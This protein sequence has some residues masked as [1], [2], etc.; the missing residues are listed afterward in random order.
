MTSREG[1]IFTIPLEDGREALCRVLYASSYFKDVVLLGCY[2]C[3]LPTAEQVDA[4]PKVMMYT[5]WSKAWSVIGHKPV[6]SHERTFSRR[7]VAGDV[8]EG[9]KHMGQAT[10]AELTS[11]PKMEVFGHRILARKLAQYV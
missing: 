1:D 4:N 6:D 2:G 9:D 11:L 5:G 3:S 10:E 7:I 8:W